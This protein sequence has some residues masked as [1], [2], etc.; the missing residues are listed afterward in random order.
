MYNFTET[1]FTRD[2]LNDTLNT[3]I[4]QGKVETQTGK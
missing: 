4:K 2:K 3:K 1:E